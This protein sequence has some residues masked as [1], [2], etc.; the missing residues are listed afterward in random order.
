MCK[1]LEIPNELIATHLVIM[2]RVS[3]SRTLPENKEPR[4]KLSPGSLLGVSTFQNIGPF[5]VGLVVLNISDWSNTCSGIQ[6]FQPPFSKFCG[7]KQIHVAYTFVL[8]L[9]L[10][11]SRPAHITHMDNKIKYDRWISDYV[12][13]LLSFDT[14]SSRYWNR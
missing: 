5:G 9:Q 3:T 11:P 12:Q 6:V 4:S 10:V 7:C 1:A 13:A 2:S 14:K 8:R